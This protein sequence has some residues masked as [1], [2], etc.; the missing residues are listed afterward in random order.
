MADTMTNEV[1]WR[2]LGG[3]FCPS[4]NIKNYDTIWDQRYPFYVYDLNNLHI[5]QMTDEKF[6]A[7][8]IQEN[9]HS[10]NFAEYQ[11]L[12]SEFTIKTCEVFA[13]EL[14]GENVELVQDG[15][16]GGWL[17]LTNW[18]NFP[19]RQSY[20]YEPED[21]WSEK[22]FEKWVKLENFVNDENK[23]FMTMLLSQIYIDFFIGYKSWELICGK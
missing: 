9:V 10:D 7:K 18:K 2:N 15:R 11:N 8:W 6:N 12:S 14:F 3:A 16:M 13:K 19:D 17:V 1:K 4:I 23:H 21:E 22:D 20:W 5:A